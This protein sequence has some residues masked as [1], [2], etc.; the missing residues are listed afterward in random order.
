M[1]IT[2]PEPITLIA[3][4]VL[5]VLGFLVEELTRISS[6]ILSFSASQAKQ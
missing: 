1:R 2:L 6:T 3:G 4:L 5:V